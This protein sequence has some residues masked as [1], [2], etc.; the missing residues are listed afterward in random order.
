[1]QNAYIVT[2]TLIDEHTI[3]LDETLPLSSTKVRLILE[4]I[5][6]STPR[7]Y[8]TLMTEI[9]A[10]QQARGHRPPTREEVDAMLQTE[11]ESWGE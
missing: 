7:P 2:G 6:S 8:P 5:A 1:M 9:R 10:R 3:T 4:P 11:R